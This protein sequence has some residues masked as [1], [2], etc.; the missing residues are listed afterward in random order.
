MLNFVAHCDLCAQL[1]F[2][3]LPGQYICLL[4]PLIKDVYSCSDLI[5]SQVRAEFKVDNFYLME[6]SCAYFSGFTRTCYSN[7]V[8]FKV[9]GVTRSNST[10]FKVFR[11]S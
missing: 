11:V 5:N 1:F 2:V 3:T 7:L 4:L 10:L 6:I 9:L 8:K